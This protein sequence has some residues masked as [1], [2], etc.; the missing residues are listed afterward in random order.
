MP[1]DRIQLFGVNNRDLRSF[2]TDVHRGVRLLQ[3]SPQGVVRV[4][5]SGLST[6]DDLSMLVKNGIDAAL[7][8]ESLMR[9]DDPGLALREL[10]TGTQRM[11]EEA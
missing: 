7:I 5:E 2:E 1:W 10:L 8:G 3:E 9:K 6:A 11:L 4:S